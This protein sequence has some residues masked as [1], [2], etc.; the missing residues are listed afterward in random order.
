MPKI[1]DKLYSSLVNYT[2]AF[3]K[4]YQWI[5]NTLAGSAAYEEIVTEYIK[6]S[7]GDRILDIGCGPA[8]IL[9]Y[10]QDVEYVGFDENQKYIESAK[11]KFGDRAIFYCNRIGIDNFIDTRQFN[12]VIAIAVLH[13]LN[14]TEALEL[15]R[16]A[17]AALSP[18]GRFLT[19]DPCYTEAQSPIARLLIHLDR[20]RYVRTE[21]HYI[22]IVSSIFPE[23][24]AYIRH[25]RLRV[26][27]THIVIES[28]ARK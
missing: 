28:K 24:Q 23:V 15:C 14:D 10:I 5:Q 4:V 3:P 17:Q 20:G 9:G 8:D 16:I 25:D 13:H 18:G 27:Y 21:K 11:K 19:I 26:P 6:P 22:E 12:I 2:L 7:F 1:T